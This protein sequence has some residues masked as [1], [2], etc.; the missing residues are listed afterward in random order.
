MSLMAITFTVM[1]YNLYGWNALGNNIGT[2]GEQLMS[3]INQHSPDLLATSETEGHT[4]WI[5]SKLPGYSSYGEEAHGVGIFY[6]PDVW[7]PISGGL[8]LLKEHDQWGQRVM[9]WGRFEHNQS[10][11]K[12]SFYVTHWCV[13]SDDTLLGSAETVAQTI[14][15]RGNSDPVILSGDFNVFSGFEK[16]KA[17]Q[18]LTGKLNSAPVLLYDTYRAVHPS[19]KGST[20]GSAGKIDYLLATNDIFTTS[21]TIDYNAHGSDHFP[22]LATV[23][24]GSQN[25]NP[26]T[27]NV[28]ESEPED[29]KKMFMLLAF[30]ISSLVIFIILL[31]CMF[32]RKS[33]RTSKKKNQP[34]YV[35]LI[36]TKPPKTNQISI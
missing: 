9:R 16:S 31:I 27:T 3:T 35:S 7:T 34:G 32:K 5:L 36:S 11:K 23:S 26:S 19:G 10:G 20:F 33:K 13:C 25:Q 1:Q 22:V 28:S 2:L 14:A 30:I 6:K 29:K 18:Y 4:D 15:N 12:V 8:V 21:S 17:I 24:I